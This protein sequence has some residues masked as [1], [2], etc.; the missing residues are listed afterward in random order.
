MGFER[1]TNGNIYEG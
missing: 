1:F